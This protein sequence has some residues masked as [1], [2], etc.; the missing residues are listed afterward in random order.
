MEYILRATGEDLLLF[1][2]MKSLVFGVYAWADKDERHQ[3]KEAGTGVFVAPGVGLTA[4][5]VA[6]SFR[7]L[8]SRSDSWDRRKSP[9]DSQ[10]RTFS[11]T[12]EYAALVYQVTG[13]AHLP[14][15][16]KQIRWKVNVNWPSHDTD[17]NVMRLE[18]NS[19][20]AE[21]VQ[22]EQRYFDWY[23]KPP[24]KGAIVRVY[25]FPKAD[26]V[27]E[28]VDHLVDVN[29]ELAVTKVV[30]HFYP[31]HDHGMANFP[32]FQLHRE[33]DD[34]FSGGPVL[35]HDKLVGLFSGPAFVTP[36]W[37]TALLTY[38]DPFLDCERSFADHFES[39]LIHTL[40]WREVKGKVERVPCTE[41][42]VGTA[43]QPC[44]KMHAVLK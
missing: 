30:D 15:E 12:S 18:P 26:V 32:V 38:P 16:E 6:Q 40:D 1:E 41:A 13:N 31:I 29:L 22:R 24:P 25:G 10:Y 34:G 39:G 2:R 11:V 20:A 23:L 3:V 21:G 4:R 17:I 44:T 35:W 37:P 36:L 42:V 8:D 43:H 14:P 5:H 19:T 9:L 7:R 28:G 33:L 27:V